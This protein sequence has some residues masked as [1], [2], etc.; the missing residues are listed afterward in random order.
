VEGTVEENLGLIQS[1]ALPMFTL[2]HTCGGH[3]AAG[4]C[5]ASPTTS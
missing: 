3:D 4:H 2:D 1:G 5:A